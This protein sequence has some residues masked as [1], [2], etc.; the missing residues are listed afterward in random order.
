MGNKTFHIGRL[1]AILAEKNAELPDGHKDR[2]FS[3]RV[4]FDG[5]DVVDR[6]KNAVL[7][8]ELSSSPAT[9]Q[10]RKAAETCGLF[11]GHDVQ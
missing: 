6:D 9:A 7:F 11:P 8:Q 1:F 3:G 4:V 10:A 5:T 2:K